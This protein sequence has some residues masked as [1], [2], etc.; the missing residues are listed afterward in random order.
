MINNSPERKNKIHLAT[1]HKGYIAENSK[2]VIVVGNK[3]LFQDI[4]PNFRLGTTIIY[5]MNILARVENKLY[6]HV[7]STK[8]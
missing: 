4:N 8:D 7:S 3:F 5:D 2:T 6:Q 1:E